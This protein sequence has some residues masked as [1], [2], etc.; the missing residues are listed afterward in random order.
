[1]R[2]ALLLAAVLVVGGCSVQVKVGS[3]K[4]KPEGHRMKSST[5]HVTVEEGAAGEELLLT[6]ADLRAVDG[7]PGDLVVQSVDKTEL[8]EN[9][10]PRVSVAARSRRRRSTGR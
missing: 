8:Y 7:L 10:D 3:E 5:P 6:T 4:E 2:R 1:M 9:P